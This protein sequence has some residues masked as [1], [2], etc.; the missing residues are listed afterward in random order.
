MVKGKKMI[1]TSGTFARVTGYYRP[2]GAWNQGKQ[3]EHR[4]RTMPA[5]AD[6]IA[7]G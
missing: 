1:R 6:I 2:V 7:L 5:A 4:D 3:Q